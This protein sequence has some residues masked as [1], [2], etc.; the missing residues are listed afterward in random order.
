[1]IGKL[2]LYGIIVAV[3]LIA[4]LGWGEHRHT[5]GVESE[6]QR[7]EAAAAKAREADLASLKQAIDTANTIATDTATKVA[8]IKVINKTVQGAIQREIQTNTVYSRDCL[9]DSG[10]LQW[11]AISAG[12][13]VVPTGAPGPDVDG[14]GPKLPDS[15]GAAAPQQPGWKPIAKPPGFQGNLRPVPGPVSGAGGV[16]K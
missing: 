2:E 14:S 11:D 5:Q 6:R 3:A 1:M 15:N 8:N 10:R 16:G 12:R 7:W 4:S 9:P 13:P